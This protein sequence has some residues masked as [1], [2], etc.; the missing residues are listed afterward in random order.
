MAIQITRE[1]LNNCYNLKN[2]YKDS[3]VYIKTNENYYYLKVSFVH[4]KLS[5]FLH[6]KGGI[7]PC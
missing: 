5:I 1:M 6:D 4:V 3:F 7:C 2:E